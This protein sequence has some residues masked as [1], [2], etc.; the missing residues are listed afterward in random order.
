MVFD[1]TINHAS[2]HIQMFN[3]IMMTLYPI[4]F[5]QITVWSGLWQIPFLGGNREKIYL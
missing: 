1:K 5:I 4:F 2:G 3:D